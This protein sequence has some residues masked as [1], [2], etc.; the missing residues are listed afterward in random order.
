MRFSLCFGEIWIGR[1]EI[2]AKER[3]NFAKK[4]KKNKIE[5]RSFRTPRGIFV[6]KSLCLCGEHVGGKCIP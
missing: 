2:Q 3:R 1:L 6:S 5:N 4:Q